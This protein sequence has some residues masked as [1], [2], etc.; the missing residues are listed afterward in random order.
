MA[1]FDDPTAVHGAECPHCQNWQADNERDIAPSGL[2]WSCDDEQENEND[3]L[4]DDDL[5]TLRPDWF[6]VAKAI[7]IPRRGV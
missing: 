7:V 1:R 4:T 6:Q 3:R 2:C 5:I